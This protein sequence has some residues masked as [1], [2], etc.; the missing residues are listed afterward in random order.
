MA[1]FHTLLDTT[2]TG[3]HLA[4]QADLDDVVAL[5]AETPEGAYTIAI[6]QSGSDIGLSVLTPLGAEPSLTN[7]V[8]ATTTTASDEIAR[9]KALCSKQHAWLK[10]HDTSYEEIPE[11]LYF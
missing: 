10:T 8:I 5:T 1:Q 11:E 4:W 9:L 7:S 2:K 6:N 3:P